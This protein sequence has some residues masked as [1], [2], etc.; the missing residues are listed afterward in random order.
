MTGAPEEWV[1]AVDAVERARR[2]WSVQL[3][4]QWLIDPAVTPVRDALDLAL[5]RRVL[6]HPR[7]VEVRR[8]LHY[9]PPGNLGGEAGHGRVK[10]EH[11]NWLARLRR[12]LAYLGALGPVEGGERSDCDYLIRLVIVPK[13]D[14]SP[15]ELPP[16]GIWIDT[17]P[18]AVRQVWGTAGLIVLHPHSEPII[19]PYSDRN[20][21]WVG[22]MT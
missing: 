17:A 14:R 12:Q 13:T 16:D 19:G 10:T 9:D 8:L 1:D 11:E 15:S 2:V 5:F 6:R 3:T 18:E 22:N 4:D 21:L 7:R 20:P